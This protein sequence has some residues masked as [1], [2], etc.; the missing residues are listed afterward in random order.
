MLTLT[1]HD[2][3]LDDLLVAAEGT[4][5]VAL[6]PAGLEV[7]RK[8]RAL[9]DRTIADRIPVYGVTTGLGAR[10]TETLDAETLA[11]FS[12]QTL[13]GRAHAIGNPE[14]R[15]V[16]RAAMIL[17]AN[18]LLLGYAGARIEVA[19]HIINC[20][21]A[22]LTPLVGDTGS[23]G[24][25]DLIPNA[26]LGLSLAGEG[27]MINAAGQI[28]ASEKMMLSNGVAPLT[29][30]PRDGLALANH[31]SMVT[32]SAA[33][34]QGAARNSFRAAQ[35][36]AALSLQA[37]GANLAP[38][39][40]R[41]LSLR[42][43]HGQTLAAAELRKLLAGSR[44]WQ[45]GEARRLQD[46]LSFRNIP[47]VH[48]TLAAAL[49]ALDEHLAIELNGSSDNPAVL[50]DNNEVLSTGNYFA[51]ELA[52]VVDSVNRAFVHMTVAQLARISKHLNPVFSGLPVFLALPDSGSNGFAPLMK[53]AEA[54]V[55][56]LL[57][58]AQP[59]PIW[60]SINANGVEDCVSGAPVAM[61]SLNRIAGL[62]VQLSAI[63]MIVAAQ[64]IDLR[65]ESPEAMGD[66]A[67]LF[68]DVRSLSAP[69][70]DDRPLGADV[71]EIGEKLTKM[72]LFPG[73][74][75]CNG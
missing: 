44:L 64:A 46:P 3:S 57:Q 70:M 38:F 42:P 34:G 65:K 53:T 28:G 30:G 74:T 72:D 6:A 37:F 51:S 59:G 10:V 4:T 40:D 2:L 43:L 19:E 55:A 73:D 52:N 11:G 69:L 7:M 8:S 68:M 47:Q 48:G 41:L 16:I 71:M 9:I 24:A 23:I 67:N 20:L 17:R 29:L 58:A 5:Q 45:A 12:L 75:P 61:K 50:V 35:S 14:P 56:D 22:D 31:A 18:T 32:A 62:S 15:A 13:R 60:P 39:S 66:I 33:I 27:Q 26:T 36:A 1:G 21:N 63:E 54:I 25:A 49:S